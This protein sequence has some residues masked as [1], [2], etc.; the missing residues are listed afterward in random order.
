MKKIFSLLAAAAL[1]VPAMAYTVD[2]EHGTDFSGGA[3]VDLNNDG[4]LDLVYGGR[5][6]FDQGRIVYD[7]DGNE[8]QTIYQSWQYIWNPTAGKYDI[9]EFNTIFG[10]RVYVNFADFNNDGNMDYYAC[11]SANSNEN[12]PQGIFIG[13]GDATFE[14]VDMVV[15]DA[16]GNDFLFRPTASDVA[17]FNNDG[18][19][20]I[21]GIGWL[22][23]EGAPKSVSAVLINK[24]DY[25][26]LAT[27]IDLIPYFFAL[28]CVR[29]ADLNNDGYADFMTQ[30]NADH[31]SG[32]EKNGMVQGRAFEIYMNIGQDAIDEGEVMF[33]AM[34]IASASNIHH[35]GN[36][37]FLCADFNNDG[38]MD[39]FASGES[40]DD[41]KPAGEW[42]FCHQMLINSGDADPIFTPLAQ[43]L[44]P[45]DI[46]PLNNTHSGT[47][48]IDYDF[49]GDVDIFLPGWC[50]T[51]PDGT[52]ATQAGFWWHNNG[53]GVI[54]AYTRIPGGSEIGIFF[55]EDGVQGAR[56]YFMAG[57]TSDPTYLASAGYEGF[58]RFA[59]SEANPN[60]KGPRPEAPTNLN[61]AVDGSKVVLSWEPAASAQ[62][63]FTY[64]FFIKNANGEL[65]NSVT[66]FVG[67]ELDGVRKL[68][69]Q[70]GAY[71]NK[72]ITFNNLP[73]GSYTWGV[74]AI[75]AAYEGSVFAV[76]EFNLGTGVKA[77][78]AADVKVAAKAGKLAVNCQGVATV[79]VYSTVGALVNQVAIKGN[80]ELNLAGGCYIVKVATENGVK[81]QKVI[82]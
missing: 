35:L 42:A 56:N 75:N 5:A 14:Q 74:Q 17:D 77:V 46:R 60:T 39:I 44:L 57:G 81:V 2:L 53:K 71:L 16:D 23:V 47:R 70:G 9:S 15:K 38:H 32:P 48:A 1:V 3:E 55:T 8:I 50:T 25:N 36:G 34:D 66:S 76:G 45:F 10:E 29:V 52:D 6:A 58:N 82:L 30:G 79:S 19:M 13:K 11:S 80:A 24:G 61:V 68:M 41:G 4:N 59:I 28:D 21:V 63:N 7:V 64:E 62:N 72:E 27:N 73:D 12:V 69:N 18:L 33:Y 43:S 20:D 37:N 40:P 22:N 67:G 78:E 31:G 54:D 51:M 65:M 26:F 49:D